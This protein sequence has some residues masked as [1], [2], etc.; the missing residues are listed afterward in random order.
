MIKEET[1]T[2]RKTIENKDGTI[3]EEKYIVDIRILPKPKKRTEC[4]ND[5]FSY[6]NNKCKILKELDCKNQECRFYQTEKEHL[7]KVKE[8]ELRRIK[9]LREERK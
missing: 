1:K 6:K 4:L 2:I 9:K 7:E 3:T 8:L 5:C